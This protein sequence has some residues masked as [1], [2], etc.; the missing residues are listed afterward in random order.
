MG[1]C[2]ELACLV[3]GGI[4][5]QAKAA[6]EPRS[7]ATPLGPEFGGSSMPA[8]NGSLLLDYFTTFVA[9]RDVEAFQNR[10]AARYNEGDSLP[11]R[12]Q[13]ARYGGAARRRAGARA[14]GQLRA[15]Q[16]RVGQGAPRS[17]CGGAHHGRRLTLGHLVSRRH[18]RAE[19]PAQ[20][21]ATLDQ[22]T[23]ARPGRAPG[24]SFDRVRTQFCR[25]V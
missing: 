21:G 17:R 2:R 9:D 4:I 6:R 23:A 8:H 11:D 14:S 25:G 18:S 10:V 7:G 3:C 15:Q 24:Q 16:R 12:V 5:A 20:S 19:S 22:P 1:T 13:L